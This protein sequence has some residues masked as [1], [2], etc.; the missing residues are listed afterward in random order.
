MDCE[1]C[2]ELRPKDYDKCQKDMEYIKNNRNGTSK[3]MYN[4]S[5]GT[6]FMFG[7]KFTA[8]KSNKRKKK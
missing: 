5:C 4:A 1:C 6:V 8:P 2:K 3:K 7:A